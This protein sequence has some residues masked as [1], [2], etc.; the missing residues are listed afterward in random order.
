MSTLP[1]EPEQP[2]T[3]EQVKVWLHTI[4]RKRLALLVQ[5]MAPWNSLPQQQAFMEMSDLLQEALEEVRVISTMLREDSQ[6]LRAHTAGVW[7]HAAQLRA[8]PHRMTNTA[9]HYREIRGE[10]LYLIEY[11]ETYLIAG[12]DAIQKEIKKNSPPICTA[13]PSSHPSLLQC[14]KSFSRKE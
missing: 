12:D 1:K 2:I 3:A 4:Q 14:L 11:N 13:D 9:L 10:R 6:A 5:A 7:E 8:R